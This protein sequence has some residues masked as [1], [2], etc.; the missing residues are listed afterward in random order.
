VWKPNPSQLGSR[1]LYY[2]SRSAGPGVL[3]WTGSAHQL[4]PHVSSWQPHLAGSR[5]SFS[6]RHRASTRWRSFTIELLE[7]AQR[8][9]S[10]NIRD[11]AP[12]LADVR[13][14][15]PAPS[16]HSSTREFS[17]F[18]LES[19]ST[20]EPPASSGSWRTR[21]AVGPASAVMPGAV[22]HYAG[23][24]RHQGHSGASSPSWR[25]ASTCRSPCDLPE[26]SWPGT[27]SR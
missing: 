20:E 21:A 9:G 5:T 1:G 8:S 23:G 19:S 4:A 22:P 6:C 25:A 18:Q 3:R 27:R 24:T 12:C 13:N 2:T 17:A 11:T 10:T 15:A 14:D 7:F 26:Q 16:Q